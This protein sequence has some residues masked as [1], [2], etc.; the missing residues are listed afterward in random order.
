VPLACIKYKPRVNFGSF[1]VNIKAIICEKL[2]IELADSIEIGGFKS[3]YFYINS[4]M[5]SPSIID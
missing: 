1:I 5:N 3:S 2:D 4:T